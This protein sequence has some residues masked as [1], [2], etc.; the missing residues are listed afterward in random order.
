M[1][2]LFQQV[3]IAFGRACLDELVYNHLSGLKTRMHLKHNSFQNL[4]S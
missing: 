4:C 1:T 2:M 3:L